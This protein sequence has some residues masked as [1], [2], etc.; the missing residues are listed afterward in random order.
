MKWILYDLAHVLF[1]DVFYGGEKRYRHERAV[2]SHPAGNSHQ[3]R[4]TFIV[5]PAL[6]LNPHVHQMRETQRQEADSRLYG[7]S[8]TKC[9]LQRSDKCSVL[10]GRPSRV[11]AARE[12]VTDRRQRGQRGACVNPRLPYRRYS[13]SVQ[14]LFPFCLGML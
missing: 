12:R 11:V 13:Y 6:L 7:Q 10:P 5:F 2:F 8:W 1:P 14:L 4:C 3:T 9:I